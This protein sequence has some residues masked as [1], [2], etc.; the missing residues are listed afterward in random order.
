MWFTLDNLIRLC[1]QVTDE[2]VIRAKTQLK[3][4]MMMQLG[5]V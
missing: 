5:T 4:N 2:E 1:H 3:A